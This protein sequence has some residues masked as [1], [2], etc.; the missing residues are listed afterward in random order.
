MKLIQIG[1]EPRVVEEQ[2]LQVR[3]ELSHQMLPVHRWP[4]FDV[5]STLLDGDRTRLHL[6]MAGTQRRCV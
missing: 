3:E 6:G 2:L 5:R 4:L 1:Q